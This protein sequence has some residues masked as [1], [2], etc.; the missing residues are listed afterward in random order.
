MKCM[1]NMLTFNFSF[2]IFRLRDDSKKAKAHGALADKRRIR[3]LY[4][5]IF[6]IHRVHFGTNLVLNP[7]NVSNVAKVHGLFRP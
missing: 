6:S 3:K 2:C 4:V 5:S 1:E 7:R